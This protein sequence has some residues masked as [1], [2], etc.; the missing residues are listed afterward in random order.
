LEQFFFP[1]YI[2]LGKL[3]TK[4]KTTGGFRIVAAAPGGATATATAA[5]NVNP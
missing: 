5:M 4:K 3:K 2:K 1:L